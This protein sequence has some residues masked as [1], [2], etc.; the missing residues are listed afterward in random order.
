HQ[1]LFVLDHP[2]ATFLPMLSMGFASIYSAEYAYQLMK[3]GTPE[4]PNAEPI[5]SGPFVFKRFQ[6]DAVVRYAANPE[7]FAGKPA[8][9]AL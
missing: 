8:V 1:V 5:G 9:D 4:K 2:D 7:Y 3:A 6:K